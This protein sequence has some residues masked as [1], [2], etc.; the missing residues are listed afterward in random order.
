M[1]Q[2]PFICGKFSFSSSK[3]SRPLFHVISLWKCMCTS[4]IYIYSCF[5]KTATVWGTRYIGTHALSIWRCNCHLNLCKKVHNF[6][7]ALFILRWP[8]LTFW[9]LS[10]EYP[11]G[12]SYHSTYIQC[13]LA[14]IGLSQFRYS[15]HTQ[16]L[17]VV[18]VH[19]HLCSV[20][21]NYIIDGL[22]YTYVHM[23]GTYVCICIIGDYYW[24]VFIL[25]VT[26]SC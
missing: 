4:P 15:K 7:H 26:L 6:S 1:A 23:Y 16:Q 12:Q 25:K 3:S 14:A 2:S 13:W 22:M 17:N 19:C 18:S 11:S 21:L 9:P 20:E 24:N 10:R 5:T 8:Q